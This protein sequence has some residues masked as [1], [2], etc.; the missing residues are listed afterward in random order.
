MT[1]MDPYFPPRILLVDDDDKLRTLMGL[2]L[3]NEGYVISH[4]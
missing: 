4:A 1:H 3:T 2:M